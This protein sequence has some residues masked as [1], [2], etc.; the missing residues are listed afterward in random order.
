MPYPEGTVIP[1]YWEN[2]YYHSYDAETY[3]STDT[4]LTE[5]T[6]SF[7]V[8]LNDADTREI[9]LL[10]QPITAKA[11]IGWKMDGTDVMEAVEIVRPIPIRKTR[12]KF[13]WKIDW[14]T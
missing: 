6:W 14:I 7:D 12:K 1:V 9:E 8:P 10:S 13:Q 11:C 4:L 3:E 5:G 2:L